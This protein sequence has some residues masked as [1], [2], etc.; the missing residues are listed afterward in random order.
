MLI[1]ITEFYKEARECF[2]KLNDS[3]ESFNSGDKDLKESI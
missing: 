2:Y 1:E 3:L